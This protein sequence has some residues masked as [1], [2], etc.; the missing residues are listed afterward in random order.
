MSEV[1]TKPPLIPDSGIIDED[2]IAW[3]QEW[4]RFRQ[5]VLAQVT[6][7][8]DESRSAEQLTQRMSDLWESVAAESKEK[9]NWKLSFRPESKEEF[10]YRSDNGR[11]VQRVTIRRHSDGQWRFAKREMPQGR[12]SEKS[13]HEALAS[14]IIDELFSWGDLGHV[15]LAKSLLSEG[16]VPPCEDDE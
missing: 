13:H 6:A 10:N 14:V 16:F 15:G 8:L 2:F 7:F 12:H 5:G 1:P 11:S 3:K 4:F 9:N